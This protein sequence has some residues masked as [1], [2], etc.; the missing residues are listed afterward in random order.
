MQLIFA[1]SGDKR[2]PKLTKVAEVLGSSRMSSEKGSF[3]CVLSEIPQ[4]PSSTG[5]KALLGG[6]LGGLGPRLRESAA[7]LS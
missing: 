5:R 1:A 6:T 4:I 7:S 2:K 3:A